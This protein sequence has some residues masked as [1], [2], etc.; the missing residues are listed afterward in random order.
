MA[1]T[2]VIQK[3]VAY[4]AIILVVVA[5]VTLNAYAF[6]KPG[7][8]EKTA[9]NFN[10]LKA[11]ETA[12]KCATPDGYTDEAWREHMGHHPDIYGECL[13]AK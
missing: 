4:A 10:K 6:S 7:K 8:V 1:V 13:S 2:I 5:I 12:D 11:A 3:K 9:E